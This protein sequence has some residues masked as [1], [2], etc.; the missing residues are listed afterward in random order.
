MAIYRYNRWIKYDKPDMWEV[1]PL[2][3]KIVGKVAS[4]FFTYKFSGNI[5]SD[6]G[7]ELETWIKQDN[8][9]IL[10]NSLGASCDKLP[11][12]K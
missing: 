2:A 1:E 6:S 5:T 10:I 11:P 3:I 4:V 9:W 7:K 8:K 12:C